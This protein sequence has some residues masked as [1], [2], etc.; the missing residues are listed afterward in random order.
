[1]ATYKTI[2][3]VG[4]SGPW[5]EKLILDLPGEVWPNDI[6]EQAFNV[7][8]ERKDPATGEV[9]HAKEHHGDPAPLPSRGFVPIRH[10]FVSDGEGHPVPL[11]SHVTLTLPELRLTKRIDG[12]VMRGH[13]RVSDFRVTQLSAFPAHAALSEHSAKQ[14]PTATPS[15]SATQ[16][17][18]DLPAQEAGGSPIV[19]LVWDECTED[20]CPQ[21]NG[22]DLSGV[23][24][25]DG[26]EMRYALFTPDLAAINAHRIHPV[27]GSPQPTLRKVPLVL[28]LHGAGE[29]G[30]EPYRTVTGNKVVALSEAD[31]QSKLGGAAYVLAPSC[32]TFWMDSGSGTIADDNKTIYSAAVKQLVDEIVTALADTID[33]DRIYVGGLSNGGFMTCRLLAD[34]PGFFAAG[35]GVCAPWEDDCATPDEV[36]AIAKTPLWLVQVDDDPLVSARRGPLATYWHLHELGAKDVHLTYYDHIEDET[37]VYHDE[38]GRPQRYI[39][40]LVWI[41]VYHDTPKTE[42][43]GTNVLVDGRPV[44]LWQWVGTHSLNKEVG[45]R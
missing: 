24:T 1:M 6:D 14:A 17:H 9:V 27:F 4:D 12:D 3:T 31:I 5:I 39:G 18:S 16:A 40:H 21:L 36:T 7:Y 13:L 20:L 33:T 32:P 8:V 41:N 45:L 37:G 34:Y 43:D 15:H 38:D 2:T 22:W 30:S 35:I 11:G 42:I 26:F 19:G 28:W 44:T 25:F 29:G 10:A 23:G